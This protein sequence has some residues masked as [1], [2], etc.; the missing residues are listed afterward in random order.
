MLAQN[1]G[2]ANLVGI[3]GLVT[4]A[5]IKK[6]A[7]NFI[8]Y[9]FLT[10]KLQGTFVGRGLYKQLEMTMSNYLKKIGLALLQQFLI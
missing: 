7:P 10:Y 2:F 8:L 4:R 6:C 1:T 5:W 9:A 3:G